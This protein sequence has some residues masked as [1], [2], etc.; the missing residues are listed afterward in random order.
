MYL[1]IHKRMTP[2]AHESYP[3]VVLMQ[4]PACNAH[5]LNRLYT[6]HLNEQPP[7]RERKPT[8]DPTIAIICTSVSE[9]RSLGKSGRVREWFVA[10]GALWYHTRRFGRHV[11][12]L[13]PPDG[14]RMLIAV[15]TVT[16][17][18]AWELDGSLLV[19]AGHACL[20]HLLLL[21]RTLHPRRLSFLPQLAQ[22][23]YLT[24]DL[25]HQSSQLGRAALVEAVAGQPM[26]LE[27]G[28]LAAQP[29]VL[30]LQ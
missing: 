9:S 1:R 16:D 3:P 28:I 29:L 22:P 25:G 2:P 14:Q 11:I 13:A 19:A 18:P 17:V 4:R 7:Q 15:L 6:S 5:R 26:P 24:R 23:L 12:G 20:L 21:L 10:R 27:P 30:C 8:V